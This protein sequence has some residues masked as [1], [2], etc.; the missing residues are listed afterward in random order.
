MSDQET[1]LAHEHIGKL[2]RQELTLE[3]DSKAE[4]LKIKGVRK[5]KFVLFLKESGFRW[6][7]RKHMYK[8]VLKKLREIPL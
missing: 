4:L 7:Y 3:S 5:D 2:R 1:V 6:N 8:V